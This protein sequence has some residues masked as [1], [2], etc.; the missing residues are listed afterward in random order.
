MKYMMIVLMLV[1]Y[2][3]E[4]EPDTTQQRF[5]D[6]MVELDTL[7]AINNRTLAGA[8][9]LRDSMCAAEPERCLKAPPAGDNKFIITIK[10]EQSSLSVNPLDHIANIFDAYTFEVP[11][12]EDFYNQI[13]V[14]DELGN[15]K[16]YGSFVASGS[17]SYVKAIVFDKNIS[18]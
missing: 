6:V 14:G 2:G 13:S 4:S 5:H 16:K 15:G 10:I 8:R 1:I 3:C 11:V 12:S 18:K 17:M 9:H 7:E